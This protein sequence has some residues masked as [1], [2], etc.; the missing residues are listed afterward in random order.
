VVAHY[1]NTFRRELSRT[2][3]LIEVERQIVS[4]RVD[5][6]FAG[7]TLTGMKRLQPG[8]SSQFAIILQ[9]VIDEV[10]RET[11]HMDM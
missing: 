8:Q 4:C 9:A 3:H 2:F 10:M 6:F 11:F 7:G 5:D 1:D